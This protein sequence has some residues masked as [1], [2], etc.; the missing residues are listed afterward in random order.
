[1]ASLMGRLFEVRKTISAKTRICIL[2]TAHP[3]IWFPRGTPAFACRDS[4]LDLVTIMAR[5]MKPI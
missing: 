4:A 2:R 3:T 5:I 1:M